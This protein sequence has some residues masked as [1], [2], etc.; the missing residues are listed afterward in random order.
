MFVVLFSDIRS[1][2]L[3]RELFRTCV[4]CYMMHE[5]TFCSILLDLLES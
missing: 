5:K 3:L 1:L 4:S 2:G